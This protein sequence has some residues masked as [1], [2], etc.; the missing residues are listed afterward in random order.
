MKVLIIGLGSIAKKHIGVLK[1]IEP[2]VQ[3]FAF[4]SSRNGVKSE[5]VADLFTWEEVMRECFDFAIISNPTALHFEVVHRLKELSLPLFIE[6]PLFSEI[7]IP[8][9]ELTEEIEKK[10]IPTYV[11]CNLRFLESL[12]E[13]KRLIAGERI[14]EVNVYC[15]SYL[16][17]WRPDADFRTVYSANKEMGGG[18]HID[19]IHELDYIYW[20]FGQPEYTRALFSN[21]SSLEISANDYA[22]YLWGYE[23]YN[24]SIILNYYRREPKRTLEIVCASGTYVVD[25]LQNDIRYGDEV[26]FS[27][28]QKMM[29]TYKAQMCFFIHRILSDEVR[30]N[31]IS[32]AYNIL[33]LCLK[34]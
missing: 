22:N 20:I 24:V 10:N 26:V 16:P 18:V 13:T 5:K 33:E 19:L 29:D 12:Q 17:D 34:Q 11:A 23:G 27:S 3:L 31:P 32:E 6:K 7:G 9:K 30:F 21:K 2:D 8:A 28:E 1:E 25:L 15:G 4:R 14:N